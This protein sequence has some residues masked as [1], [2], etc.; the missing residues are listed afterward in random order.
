[1]MKSLIIYAHPWDGSFNHAILEDVKALLRKQGKAVDVIDLYKDGF[2]P[3]MSPSDLRVFGR[4]EYSDPLAEDYVNRLKAADEVVFI[5]PLWWYGEPAMLKGFFDKVLL[6]GHTYE[7]VDFG[8][9]PLLNIKR[10]TLITTA[11]IDERSLVDYFGDPLG[12]RLIH[13]IFGMVG[14]ANT[15]WLHCGGVHLEEVRSDFL[16][17]INTRFGSEG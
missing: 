15:E 3:V 2:N 16:A 9:K 17:R 12:K 13:G 6:K 11:A 10:S 14:I 8:I 4:G 5:Y 7:Q 1:M